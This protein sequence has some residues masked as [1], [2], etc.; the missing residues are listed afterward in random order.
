MLYVGKNISG[1]SHKQY[2]NLKN[3]RKVGFYKVNTTSGLGQRDIFLGL[4]KKQKQK[5]AKTTSHNEPW[6]FNWSLDEVMWL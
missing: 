5:E 4:V 1:A 3:I 6:S 2:L